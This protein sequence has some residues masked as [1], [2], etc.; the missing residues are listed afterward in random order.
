MARIL[1]VSESGYYKWLRRRNAPLT[2][3]EQEELNLTEEIYS[4][5]KASHYSYGSR[6]ITAILNQ[7]HTE[8][9]NH[10]RVERIMQKYCWHSKVRRKYIVTT[11]SDHDFPI[12]PNLLKRDFSTDGP[13]QKMVSDTTAIPTGEGTLYV[14]GILDLYGRRPVGIALSMHNDR[15]LVLDALEDMILR[16]FKHTGAILHSD[17]GSTYCSGEYRQAIEDAG[18][19]CSM[20]RKGD[21]WDNAPMECFWGKMKSEW[22]DRD[23]ETIAEAAADVYEYCWSFYSKQRIHA[24][25]N[26]TTPERYYNS[27]THQPRYSMI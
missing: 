14:A 15:F 3:R 13:G 11:D 18:M 8:P 4:I 25:L 20:S 6:K 5:F 16:G 26:Y 7:R 27:W 23:Y 9:I 21:C 24:S 10:K 2:V 1:S 12:A 22:M 19:I 17:R